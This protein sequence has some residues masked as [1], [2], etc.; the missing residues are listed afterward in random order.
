M[1]QPLISMDRS[2]TPEAADPSSFDG[3][4]EALSVDTPV[5]SPVHALQHEL[6]RAHRDAS[7]SDSRGEKAPGWVRLGFPI[8]ASS[9]LWI[10][11]IGFI[12]A[13]A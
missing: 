7:T 2:T 10:V 13:L 3:P 4:R 8:L 11:I 12:Q 5:H 9:I 1:P 6:L